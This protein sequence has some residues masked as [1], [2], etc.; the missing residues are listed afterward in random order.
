ME[1]KKFLDVNGYNNIE[2]RRF[3][4]NQG[5]YIEDDKKV[6]LISF[7][8]DKYDAV[9]NIY[10]NFTGD[11]F[12]IID[13]DGNLVISYANCQMTKLERYSYSSDPDVQVSLT[14][15]A[16]DTNGINITLG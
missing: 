16:I 6:I 2:I 7:T 5:T 15:E 4:E 11:T 13:Q 10:N 3:T 14:L 12:N 1:Y 8:G 9:E